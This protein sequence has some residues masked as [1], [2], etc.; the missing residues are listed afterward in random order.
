EDVKKLVMELDDRAK[1]ATRTIRIVS[2]KGVDPNLLDQAISAITG[3]SSTTRRS[4]SSSPG[5]PDFPSRN[6]GTPGGFGPGGTGFP[7]GVG[8]GMGMSQ[9]PDLFADRVTEDPKLADLYDPLQANDAT[10]DDDTLN[11]GAAPKDSG[12]LRPVRYEE[13]QQPPPMPPAVFQAE[14]QAP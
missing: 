10:S 9:G 5:F 8:G 6:S 2:I 7:G 14:V 1:D 11:L 4:S 3:S 12:A 13:Q